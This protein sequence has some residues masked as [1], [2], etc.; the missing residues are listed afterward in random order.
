MEMARPL[1]ATYRCSLRDF[2]IASTDAG[3]VSAGFKM[4]YLRKDEAAFF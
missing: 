3:L 4:R 2:S 1:S